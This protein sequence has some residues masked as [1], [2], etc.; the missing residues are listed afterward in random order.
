MKAAVRLIMGGL[1]RVHAQSPL[2]LVVVA[3]L[4][5]GHTL[6]LRGGEVTTLLRH[7]EGSLTAQSLLCAI[8]KNMTKT[9]GDPIHLL[10][11]MV[12]IVMLIMVMRRGRRPQTVMDPLHA[13]GLPGRLQDLLQDPA[14]GPPTLLL[15]AV[16]DKL[17]VV[18]CLRLAYVVIRPCVGSSKN[19]WSCVLY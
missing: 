10:V 18:A 19:P 12:T 11:G 17:V 14:L 2:A 9:S 15:P 3:V 5:Q 8:Q 16:T 4:G 7:G 1:V 6:L 13:V